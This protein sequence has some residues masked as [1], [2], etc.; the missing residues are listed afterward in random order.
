MEY[1][2]VALHLYNDLCSLD[3][4]RLT[5]VSY[6]E[7]RKVLEYSQ[8]SVVIQTPYL[9]KFFIH[10]RFERGVLFPSDLL[11]LLD[12]LKSIISSGTINSSNSHLN[13]TELGSDLYMIQIENISEEPK[14]VASLE[15]VS[16]I[17]KVLIFFTRLRS[18]YFN[19]LYLSKND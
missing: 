10:K 15:Y 5:L 9:S 1:K 19:K 8:N 2:E 4:T 12:T 3:E 14:L 16:T 17:N 11:L 13:I 6:D 18:K 7:N